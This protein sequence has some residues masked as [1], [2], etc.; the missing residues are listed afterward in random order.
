MCINSKPNPTNGNYITVSTDAMG[1]ALGSP[2]L[3]SVA[4]RNQIQEM[5]SEMD[6]SG[7]RQN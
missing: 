5:D 3:D 1:Q 4:D 2:R 6:R 7:Q